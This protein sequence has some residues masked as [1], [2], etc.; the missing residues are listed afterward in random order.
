MEKTKIAYR[1]DLMLKVLWPARDAGIWQD[2]KL[3]I[4]WIDCCSKRECPRSIVSS[5]P[6]QQQGDTLIQQLLSG[7]LDII[8]GL[9]FEP[10]YKKYH[11]DKDEVVFFGQ[12][13]NRFIVK[14]AV[15]SDSSIQELDDLRGKK[16]GVSTGT[17]EFTRN[18]PLYLLQNGLVVERDGV[19]LV[20]LSPTQVLEQV[21]S[22]KV[23][24]G[25]IYPPQDVVA[26]QAGLKVIELPSFPVIY[27]ISPL[28]AT[29][30][31]TEHSDTATSFLRGIGEAVRFYKSEKDKV[32]QGIKKYFEYIYP[33]QVYGEERWLSPKDDALLESI[34][35]EERPI[36]EERPLPDPLAIN[37]VY[38][39]TAKSA[40]EEELVSNPLEAWDL[41]YVKH[42]LRE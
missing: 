42:A 7:K 14:L 32:I 39:V 9:H 15:K 16:I 19:G 18:V 24:A 33:D 6:H 8:C 23:D 22:G 25:F 36:L 20:S 34:Y 3:D 31:L 21:R 17:P 11:T 27:H 40:P 29:S 41:N 1:S 30:Y 37:N 28:A 35:E 12:T 5:L 38:A 2:H 26:A 10:Y 4:E 13:V